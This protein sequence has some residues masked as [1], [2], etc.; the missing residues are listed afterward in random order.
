MKVTDTIGVVGFVDMGR[1]DVNSFFDAAGGW[2]AGAGLG[3]RYATAVG[4]IRLDL[5]VPVG[6]NTGDGLQ[7]YVG[8]GQ[9]F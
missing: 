5:A 9:A 2:H 7:I 8:L 1:V 3:V 4:P 6:G